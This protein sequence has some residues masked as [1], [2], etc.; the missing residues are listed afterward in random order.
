MS[1]AFASED[2][3]GRAVMYIGVGTLLL[4]LVA[5]VLAATAITLSA[6]TS[7]SGANSARWG[8]A[9]YLAAF[10]LALAAVSPGTTA[11][12][13][14][15]GYIAAGCVLLPRPLG[16][17]TLLG[18]VGLH[19]LLTWISRVKAGLTGLPV[20]VLDIQIALANPSGL[21]DAL[22]L[23][24]WTRYL[25]TAVLA[26]GFLS[27]P[28]AALWAGGRLVVRR[29]RIGP[30]DALRVV[31]VC[32]LGLMIHLYLQNVY[33]EAA[34]DKSTWEPENVARLANRMG[35]LPFLAYSYRLESQSTGDIYGSDGNTLPPSAEEV[36]S[37]VLSYMDLGSGADPATRLPPNI[38]IVLAES[39]FDPGAVFRLTGEWNDE[40]F[41]AGERTAASGLLRVNA[42]GGG[43]WIT[44]FET[45]VGLDSRLFGY[46]GMYSHASLS[47]FV[48]HSI[49]TYLRDHGYHSWAFFPHGGEFYNAR[50][51]YANYGFESVLDSRDLGKGDWLE[52]DVE[53]AASVAATLGADPEQPFF[54]YILLLE[55]HVPH[56][57]NAADTANFPVRFADT[58]DFLPNCALHEYLR[59]LGSTTTAVRSL[60]DHLDGIESRTGR[61]FVLLVFC[62]HQP[63]TFASTG[64]FQYEYSALRNVADTRTTFFHFISSVPGRQLRCC[65][66]V[67][68]AAILPTLL[69]GF[70]ATSADD[71][72]LGT[73]LWL[74]ARCGSDAVQVD[75]GNFMERLNSRN[76][77]GRTPDCTKAYERALNGYRNSGVVRL[78]GNAGDKSAQS[79]V[80]YLK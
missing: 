13:T 29:A 30:G 63:H 3:T 62:D 39:T 51:A 44:E 8:L 16:W 68:S 50:N 80:D 65:S 45:I 9:V 57:C 15:L 19:V 54:G 72:Y 41:R 22:G 75:F 74:H 28:I 7:A 10:A 38:L 70:V 64:G 52:N 56:N 79:I 18:V 24:H 4:L 23:P 55:N 20:T 31:V 67:P 59:R 26:L 73:N 61:P 58:E 34:R 40:L 53:M 66:A 1:L 12:W 71:V 36:R 27:L 21:W 2:L 33:A 46:S 11:S 77:D 42:V 25:T 48:D 49:A 32:V 5:L 47:P 6:G 69:S 76:V 60:V 78:G 35:V 43:T 17:L 37:A 14:L